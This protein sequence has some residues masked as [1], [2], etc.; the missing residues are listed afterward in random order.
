[1]FRRSALYIIFLFISLLFIEC[2]LSAGVPVKLS[3]KDAAS[4]VEIIV[5]NTLEIA[6][7]GNPTTGYMWE[8]AYVDTD[9][10]IQVCEPEFRPKSDARGSGGK[11][12]MSFKAVSVGQTLLKLMYHRPFEKNKPPLRF[13]DVTVIVKR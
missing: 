1:M 5:G 6:L 9:V 7:E 3:G 4:T 13:F 2:S 11:I 8:V 10:L 12:I